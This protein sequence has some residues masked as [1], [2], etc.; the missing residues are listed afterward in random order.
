MTSN[1]V[2][3]SSERE[4][5]DPDSPSIPMVLVTSTDY[6]SGYAHFNGGHF[7]VIHR[8]DGQGHGLA[9]SEL[10]A[11]QCARDIVDACNALREQRIRGESE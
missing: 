2:D 4:K 10:E 7:V 11:R 1:V 6:E 5:R 8:R 3:L 9:M